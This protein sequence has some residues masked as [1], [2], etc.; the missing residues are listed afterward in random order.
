MADFINSNAAGNGNNNNNASVTTG[1]DG[2]SGSAG[3]M[4]ARSRH[5][6]GG[7]HAFADGHVKWVKAPD[8]WDASSDQGIRYNVWHSAANTIGYWYDP[9]Q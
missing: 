5:L 7:N 4:M 3:Y 6:G 9:S 2:S 1:R 8:V